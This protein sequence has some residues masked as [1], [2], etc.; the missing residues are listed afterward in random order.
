[1]TRLMPKSFDFRVITNCPRAAFSP[2]ANP[3]L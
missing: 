3:Q 2:F 1:L